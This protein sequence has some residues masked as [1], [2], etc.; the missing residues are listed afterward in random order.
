MGFVIQSK[1]KMLTSAVI[2]D[3]TFRQKISKER[4]DLNNNINQLDLT[5]IYKISSNSRIYILLKCT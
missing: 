1:T 2:R 5:N 3:R 4:E